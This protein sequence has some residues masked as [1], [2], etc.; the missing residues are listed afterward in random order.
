VPEWLKVLLAA[1]GGALGGGLISAGTMLLVEHLRHRRRRSDLFLEALTEKRI[2]ACREL[3]RLIKDL[4]AALDPVHYGVRHF[5]ELTADRDQDPKFR[6]RLEHIA[7]R[8]TALGNFVCANEMLLGPKVMAVIHRY[9]AALKGIEMDA[10]Y[11]D[12]KQVVLSEA[13]RKILDEFA[14][15]VAEA[16]RQE[17]GSEEIAFLSRAESRKFWEEGR[18]RAAELA[19]EVEAEMQGHLQR[20]RDA[21]AKQGGK[22]QP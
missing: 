18:K 10:E 7:E 8:Y 12:T 17:L 9:W 1:L 2:E 11:G 14:D 13:M 5:R 16:I 19:R 3:M 20:G 15:A 6:E 21:Q 4:E 22:E